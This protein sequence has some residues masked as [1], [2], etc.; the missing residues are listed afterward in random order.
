ML[1]SCQRWNFFEGKLCEAGTKSGI[2][3]VNSLCKKKPKLER[4]SGPMI[5]DVGIP[6][7]VTLF[8]GESAFVGRKTSLH[9]CYLR[10][11][12]G[13]FSMLQDNEFGK[14]IGIND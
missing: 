11:E 3:L 9:R 1:E 13:G 6:P 8:V 14:E 2:F 12:N 10:M 7:M 4:I 5:E